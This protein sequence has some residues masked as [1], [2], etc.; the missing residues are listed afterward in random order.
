MT[1]LCAELFNDL[2]AYSIKGTTVLSTDNFTPVH[3]LTA[4][5]Y[6]V[7]LINGKLGEQKKINKNFSVCRR[8]LLFC[9]LPLVLGAR[10]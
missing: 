1:T 10:G 8:A 5:L 4:N 9:I 2:R 3:N 7:N 6:I